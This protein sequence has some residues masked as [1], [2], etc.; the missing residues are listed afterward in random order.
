L[1]RI[2]LNQP[3]DDFTTMIKDYFES[4]ISTGG[5]ST[6][7]FYIFI[8]NYRH[9]N[10]MDYYGTLKSLGLACYFI[11]PEFKITPVDVSQPDVYTWEVDA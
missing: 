8:S 4:K 2:D 7:S 6:N 5:I 10:L 1:S 9:D 3:Y 11:V